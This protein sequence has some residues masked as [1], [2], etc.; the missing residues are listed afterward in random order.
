M[1]HTRT[2]I[3]PNSS[4]YMARPTKVARMGGMS[5]TTGLTKTTPILLVSILNP[6]LEE[7]PKPPAPSPVEI[8]YVQSK[9]STI[10]HTDKSCN[11]LSTL[12]PPL[13]MSTKSMKFVNLKP[14]KK[15]ITSTTS[16]ITTSPMTSDGAKQTDSENENITN[17]DKRVFCCY[18]FEYNNINNGVNENVSVDM[19][20]G[21]VDC[22][23]NAYEKGDVCSHMRFIIEKVTG[24]PEWLDALYEYGG[25]EVGQI[26][27][28]I[29]DIENVTVSF[30]V[31]GR[32]CFAC[33]NYI[34][35]TQSAGVIDAGGPTGNRKM[36]HKDCM[37][38][39]GF[40]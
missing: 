11:S 12:F 24:N 18:E 27:K 3:Q 15:C 35:G 28:F 8:V 26:D 39:L 31:S 23:C 33:Q 40:H 6:S 10:Y 25:L 14:C 2:R 21:M 4:S 20:T 34:H 7:L 5:R 37:T 1:S 32:K 22:T 38:I 17:H 29:K 19:K 13:E 36:Y 16:T 9:R 30:G